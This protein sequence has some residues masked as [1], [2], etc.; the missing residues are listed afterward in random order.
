MNVLELMKQCGCSECIHFSE[1][2]TDALDYMG[3]ST[4]FLGEWCKGYERS[5]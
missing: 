5:K 4:L 2:E 1:C 3:F